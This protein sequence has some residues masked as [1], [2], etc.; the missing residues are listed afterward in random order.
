MT[1]IDPSGRY[2]VGSF[3]GAIDAAQKL[4]NGAVAT[5]VGFG[6]AGAAAGF[7]AGLFSGPAGVAAA[8][9]FD[10]GVPADEGVTEGGV[11]GGGG[12]GDGDGGPPEDDCKRK[13]TDWELSQAG[14]DPHEAKSGLGRVSLFEICKCDSG[15]FAIK[16]KG[17]SGPIIDRL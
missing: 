10:P 2:D 5:G 3:G 7:F 11:C 9:A 6:A 1:R 12:G 13:A 4:V 8:N 16:R 14:I 17:C 15:G